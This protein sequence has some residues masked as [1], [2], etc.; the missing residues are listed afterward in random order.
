PQTPFDEPLAHIAQAVV[1]QKASVELLGPLNL[2][3][4]ATK[5]E[6]QAATEIETAIK[7]LDSQSSR[8]QDSDSDSNENS[9]EDQQEMNESDDSTPSDSSMKMQGESWTD[10]VNHSLPKPNFSAEQILQEEEENAATRAKNKP[11][12]IEKGEKDW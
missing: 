6:Q 3:V 5:S 12:R 9:D 2:L 11:A 10:M 7:F 4:R 1:D 8:S